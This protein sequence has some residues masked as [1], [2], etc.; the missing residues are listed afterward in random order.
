M[1]VLAVAL[2]PS[3]GPLGNTALEVSRPPWYFLWLHGP[4]SWFGHEAL[5]VPIFGVLLALLA[6]PFLDR[7]DELDPRRRKASMAIGAAFLLLW[8]SLTVA[9]A[10]GDP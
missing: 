5:I 4:D 1:I 9:G 6:V 10:V 2:T 7:S 8:L 3:L